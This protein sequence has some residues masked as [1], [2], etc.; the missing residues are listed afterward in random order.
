[1]SRSR[2]EVVHWRKAARAFGSNLLP[3]SREFAK[4]RFR[5]ENIGRRTAISATAYYIRFSLC[6]AV[7]GR[8]P[9]RSPETRLFAIRPHEL[10]GACSSHSANAFAEG[11]PPVRGRCSV[12]AA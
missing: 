12:P 8:Q 6:F 9:G 1:C 11:F 7:M 4:L 5:A 10:G 2:I 3:S